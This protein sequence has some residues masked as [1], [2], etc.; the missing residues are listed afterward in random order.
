VMFSS[1]VLWVVGGRAV[2]FGLSR[3]IG[4]GESLKKRSDERFLNAL[5]GEVS[6]VSTCALVVMPDQVNESS[7]ISMGPVCFA[8][9]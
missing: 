8:D 1:M 6:Q 7:E 9:R 2:G 3:R 4:V 5:G